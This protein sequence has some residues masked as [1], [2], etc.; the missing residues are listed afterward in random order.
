MTITFGTPRSL[1]SY[2][3]FAMNATGKV[4]GLE[5]FN[6]DQGKEAEAF[7]AKHRHCKFVTIPIWVK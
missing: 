1:V 5:K 2:D 7:K 3:V 4:E 6:L